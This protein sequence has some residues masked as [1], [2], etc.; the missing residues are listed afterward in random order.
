MRNAAKMH[1]AAPAYQHA[2]INPI[3]AAIVYHW[4]RGFA[5]G[6]RAQS[7]RVC[8]FPSLL[9]QVRERACRPEGTA[10]GIRAGTQEAANRR[11][12]V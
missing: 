9:A 4:E 6:L 12:E 2:R 8:S 11:Q 1:D 7:L 10:A 3:I 5:S